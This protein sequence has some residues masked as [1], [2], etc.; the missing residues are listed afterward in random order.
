MYNVESVSTSGSLQTLGYQI[1]MDAHALTISPRLLA[2]TSLQ[3]NRDYKKHSYGMDSCF[4]TSR[5][6]FQICTSQWP[7][8]RLAHWAF[9]HACIV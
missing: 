4:E 7:P 1:Q 5:I 2:T 6:A 3:T 9:A 8:G